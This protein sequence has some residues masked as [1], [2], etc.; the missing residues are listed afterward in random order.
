MFKGGFCSNVK[1]SITSDTS[2]GI[3]F[4]SFGSSSYKNF[5]PS[6]SFTSV[7]VDLIRF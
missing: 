4:L 3:K 6:A 5:A 1:R 2:Q 7:N